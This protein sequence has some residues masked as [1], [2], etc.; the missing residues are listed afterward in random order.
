MTRRPARAAAAAAWLRLF[1]ASPQAALGGALLLAIAI[2]AIFAPVFAPQD[3]YDLAA[4]DVMDSRLRP[5]ETGSTGMLHR[6]GTDDQGRDLWSAILFGLRISLGIGALAGAIA[7]SIGTTVGVLS[8][9]LGGRADTLIMRIVDFQL[10]FPA[11][12]IALVLLAALGPGIEKV[13][14]ALVA[15]QWA[16]FARTVRST[17]LVE[18]EKDY[19][20]AARS[21]GIGA[22]RIVFGHLVPNCLP[23]VLVVAAVQVANAIALEATLSFLGLG[24][25]VTQ[26][27]LGLLIANGF[28]H[29]LSG[30][31]WISAYPGVALVLLIVAINL[32][33]DRLRDMLDPRAGT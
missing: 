16:Y 24:L 29:I 17:A 12:L 25:P 31:T 1:C 7:A 11:I 15:V 5:G 6:L 9:Y 23:T 28:Q 3:P 10:S 18:R 26:P 2:V 33:G 27:S 32:V 19:I 21:L 30:R 20:S 8:A 13:I 22:P 14:F 4:L